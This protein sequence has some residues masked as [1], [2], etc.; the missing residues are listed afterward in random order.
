MLV[1]AT[2][3]VPLYHLVPSSH[4]TK[5]LLLLVCVAKDLPSAT[6]QPVFPSQVCTLT[7]MLLGLYFR[8]SW[9]SVLPSLFLCFCSYALVLTALHMW[10]VLMGS[11]CHQQENQP[12]PSIIFWLYLLIHA[13]N[14]IKF[15]CTQATGH[16]ATCPNQCMLQSTLMISR[17]NQLRV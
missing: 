1:S 6:S 2:M 5:I 10:C 15:M 12:F 14:R 7:S 3:C 17:E 4:T 16:A 13:R 9:G 8:S 11:D